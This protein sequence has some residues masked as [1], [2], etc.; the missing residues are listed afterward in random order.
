MPDLGAWNCSGFGAWPAA[1]SVLN[2]A[3]YLTA[4][5]TSTEDG[6]KAGATTAPKANPPKKFPVPAAGKQSA[7]VEP[8]AA[9]ASHIFAN[10]FGVDKPATVVGTPTNAPSPSAAAAMASPL[11]QAAS[12]STFGHTTPTS[13]PNPENPSS[14]GA[15]LP[16]QAANVN[17]AASVSPTANSASPQEG[18][19]HNAALLPVPGLSNQAATAVPAATPNAVA[20]VVVSSTNAQGSIVVVTSPTPGVIVISTNAQGSQVV[21]TMPVVSSP[22]SDNTRNLA[23]VV[24]NG[25]TL[26]TDSESQ[27][28]IAGETL[29]ANSPLVLGS[30]AS[31]TPVILRTSGIHPVLVIGSSTT[32]LNLATTSTPAP[33]APAITIGAQTITADAQ[34]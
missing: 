22:V 2:T 4:T 26:T 23:P 11:D 13:R 8:Q 24:V 3:L 15:S 31:T 17:A 20:D 10:P 28:V 7:T 14:D 29:S 32:T 25:Y 27:Y 9:E 18:D 12:G 30:G 19:S 33:T 16:A 34:G 6:D 1:A 21:T 5:S